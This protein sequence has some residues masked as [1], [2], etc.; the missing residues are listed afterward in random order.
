MR[1]VSEQAYVPAFS[2]IIQH[3]HK[4]INKKG[5]IFKNTVFCFDKSSYTTEEL[6]YY[7]SLIFENGGNVIDENIE[8]S[9]ASYMIHN[10]GGSWLPEDYTFV[11][12]DKS[13]KNNKI[14]V[15]HWFI[16][17]C[18]TEKRLIG[19]WDAK[20]LFLKPMIFKCPHEEIISKNHC[21]WFT[22]FEDLD[23]IVMNE[24]AKIVGAEVALVEGITTH[25]IVYNVKDNIWNS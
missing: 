18:L 16:L 23:S 2:D 14:N 3:K 12:T 15:S 1:K 20:A 4:K 5:K 22:L 25:I 13:E 19:L 11:K 10:D 24:L 21:Y 17:K 8:N 7:E 9:V 6:E